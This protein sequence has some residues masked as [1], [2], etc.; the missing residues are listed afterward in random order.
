MSQK[1][2]PSID[3]IDHSDRLAYESALI[4]HLTDLDPDGRWKS[5]E[6]YQL[7]RQRKYGGL[8]VGQMDD[9]LDH[10][11]QAIQD[12]TPDHYRRWLAARTVPEEDV[13]AITQLS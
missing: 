4:Q 12:L 6:L 13:I 10:L 2:L 9:L 11:N 1:P 8:T 5:H 3:Y 7:R